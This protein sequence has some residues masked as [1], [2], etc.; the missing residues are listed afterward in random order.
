M[1]ATDTATYLQKQYDVDLA[2]IDARRFRVT[3]ICTCAGDYA[4]GY[5]ATLAEAR[6][7]VRRFWWKGGH[8]ASEISEEITEA[9]CVTPDGS[10]YEEITQ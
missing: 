2:S 10:H 6:K 3:L 5:G 9:E 7:N 4:D 1:N 8:N